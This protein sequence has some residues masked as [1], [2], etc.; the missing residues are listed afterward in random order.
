LTFDGDLIVLPSYRI[1]F[2]LLFVPTVVTGQWGAMVRVVLVGRPWSGS[3]REAAP[4]RCPAA[5][6]ARHENRP[7][8]RCFCLHHLVGFCDDVKQEFLSEQ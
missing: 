4:S 3:R 2:V 7:K 1:V 5:D 8:T 6:D